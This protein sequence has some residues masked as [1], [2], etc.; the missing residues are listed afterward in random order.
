MSLCSC[1]KPNILAYIETHVYRAQQGIKT[2]VSDMTMSFIKHL[3]DSNA[4]IYF[5]N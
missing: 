4:N 5:L 1:V 2:T 3:Y